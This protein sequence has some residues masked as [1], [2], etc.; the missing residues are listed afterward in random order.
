MP[1]YSSPSAPR[2][3][4]GQLAAM[5]QKIQQHPQVSA[6][7]R[8]GNTQA[9]EYYIRTHH[10]EFG[11]D[12]PGGYKLMPNGTFQYTATTNQDHWYSDPR[13]LGPAAVAG[14]ALGI[15][16][17]GG[18]AAAA[19]GASAP[20]FAFSSTPIAAGGTAPWAGPASIGAGGAAAAGGGAAAGAAGKGIGSAL[21][22]AGKNL[23]GSLTSGEG[24]GS[25]ASLIGALTAGRGGGNGMSD[26]SQ[27][28][29]GRA[30]E[31]ARRTNALKE[32]RYTRTDPLHQMVTQLAEDRMPV[33]SRRNVT[34]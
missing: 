28:F 20:E 29:L 8:Q 13:V 27:D 12:I 24:I 26:P 23:L 18:G 7:L 34:R 33:S 3:E 4:S 2:V 6:L 9:A 1:P 17:L 14:G 32:Q 22:G 15:G 21:A 11:F 5:Q 31:D 25:L 10:N 30:Y 19:G 16:L